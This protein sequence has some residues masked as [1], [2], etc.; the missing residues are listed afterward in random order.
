MMRK[1]MARP[2]R[3]TR[4]ERLVRI[5]IGEGSCLGACHVMEQAAEL[6]PCVLPVPFATAASRNSGRCS[7]RA[8]RLGIVGIKYTQRVVLG[9]VRDLVVRLPE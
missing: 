1:A 2:S 4:V 7:S 3:R 9:R 5:E 6:L 8:G